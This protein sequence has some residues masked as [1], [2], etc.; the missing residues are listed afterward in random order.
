MTL[1]TLSNLSQSLLT[2]SLSDLG[3]TLYGLLVQFCSFSVISPVATGP[4]YMI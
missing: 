3:G 1:W 4:E 2:S